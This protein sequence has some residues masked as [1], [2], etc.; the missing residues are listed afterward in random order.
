MSITLNDNIF[1]K[2]PKDQ[3][4]KT[5]VFQSGVWRPWNNIAE[6]LASDKLTYRNRG[7][8][9]YILKD[10]QLT[11]Y[12][13][14]D[15]ILD[16]QL[17]EKKLST[18]DYY[19]PGSIVPKFSFYAYQVNNTTYLFQSLVDNNNQPPSN[20][21]INWKAIGLFHM[22]IKENL[23]ISNGLN[24][25]FVADPNSPDQDSGDIVWTYIDEEGNFVEKSRIL[26]APAGDKRVIIQFDADED[27][28]YEIIHAN[29]IDEYIDVDL[30]DYY[31]KEDSDS[32]LNN[33]AN[34]SGQ[35]FT[36][37]ISAP[38]L[39]GV[40]T[41]DQDLSGLASLSGATFTGNIA[42]PNLSGLNT[43]DQDLTPILENLTTKQPYGTTLYSKSSW[44][45]LTDFT[46]T[47]FTPTISSNK[48]L[49]FNGGSEDATK[50]II[51][52]GLVNNDDNIDIEVMFRVLDITG[53]GIAIGK[54]SLFGANNGTVGY[55]ILANSL[56][57]SRELNSIANTISDF[58]TDP[59]DY[60][61]IKLSQRG[62]QLTAKFTNLSQAKSVISYRPG[63][64]INTS[65]IV[66]YNYGGSIEISQIKVTTASNRT[67][68]TIVMGDSK[69][70]IPVLQ[71]VPSF[72]QK[73]GIV[74]PYVGGSDRTSE[75]L[76]AVP[77]IIMYNAPCVVTVNY[78]RN[79][80]ATGIPSEVWQGNYTSAVTLLETAGFTVIHLLPIPETVTA[81]QSAL[82]NWIVAN[83]TK[84]VDVSPEWD[85]A[86][87][88]AGDGVHP[89]V[90]G[91]RLIA[92]KLINSGYLP[93]KDSTQS[94]AILSVEGEY[95]KTNSANTFLSTQTIA[96]AVYPN[97][98]EAK[99]G[100]IKTSLVPIAN[101][102]RL[103]GYRFGASFNSGSGM[104]TANIN[105]GG[106]GY[107]DGVYTGVPLL[108][109]AGAAGFGAIGTVTVSGGVVISVVPT[110][111]GRSYTGSHTFTVNPSFDGSG[112]GSGFIGQVATR[113]YTGVIKNSAVFESA[114][115]NLESITPTTWTNGDVWSQSNNLWTRQSGVS[116][117]L[118]RP[119][120]LGTV[121][122][123]I[124]NATTI[125]AANGGT[126]QTVYAIGDL[127]Y[128]STTSALSKRAA[129][130]TGNVLLS[131]GIGIAPIW[132]KVTSA[133]VDSSILTSSALTPYELLANKQNSL[134]VDGTGVKYLT[135]DAANAGL[136]SKVDASTSYI[137]NTTVMQAS[138]NF[139]IS[140][141]GR[142]QDLNI[143]NRI[144]FTDNP[145]I[146]G[147][148]IGNDGGNAGPAKTLQ[149]RIGSGNGVINGL[150]FNPNVGPVV[151][152]FGSNW[153]ASFGD[154]G[155]G[156]D[157]LNSV[158]G[159]GSRYFVMDT[160]VNILTSNLVGGGISNTSGI[161][162]FQPLNLYGGSGS[163]TNNNGRPINLRG[164][165]ATGSGT[166]GDIVLFY[167]PTATSGTTV[168]SVNT[169][170]VRLN[171]ATGKLTVALAPTNPTDVVR[172][173]E[174]DLKA[175]LPNTPVTV[176]TTTQQA[177]VNTKYITNN[178]ALV[179]ITLPLD[180]N[181]NIGDQVAIRGLG[182]GLWRLAQNALQVIHGA[183]D[184]TVG[185][186][187]Y[188]QAQSRYDTVVVEKITTNEWSIVANRGTLTIA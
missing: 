87:H 12:W 131:Q 178:A 44:N 136:L 173:V 169:E 48:G 58:T 6:A 25:Y 120:V 99:A 77:Y 32:L 89:N 36:G 141:V 116:Y 165:A 15:G 103:V 156:G 132:G 75:F 4:D 114:A 172:K 175:N 53:Y 181:A 64:Y 106:T 37:N 35:V 9:I 112:L 109:L 86:I 82:Y 67:P 129:V 29:N 157:I 31:T 125:A 91:A 127:L 166:T 138:S 143:R 135:V 163:G 51:L 168:N 111:G 50:Y 13:W 177:T 161:A 104:L 128:A 10:G 81:N 16:N 62:N 154:T 155:M 119:T 85:N 151:I 17:V 69:M 92:D 158:G 54:K 1:N 115:I 97:A 19:V 184:T 7:L 24:L 121:T 140:G 162:S 26:T 167:S 30:S 142:A 72:M 90:S 79:D 21:M 102:D 152:G 42:A 188:L 83:Y 186:A 23:F 66:V 56:Q 100:Y 105:S 28:Q 33:K 110:T 174:L 70:T 18:I 22:D 160:S 123:G 93:L 146:G 52:N 183:S 179:T 147:G 63:L 159:A 144:L 55:N 122:T 59:G 149:L 80:L 84:V 57:T 134:T 108:T 124:W 68:D 187:G 182:A 2:S 133:Q 27:Q 20:D 137:Q 126:G 176:T 61:I 118:S 49:V 94:D 47:G 38:N 98:G 74:S 39:S 171:G 14:R 41:G 139:N 145:N 76:A 40:N 170:A 3:N 180:V 150:L 45:D 101:N 43:G 107:L 60:C 34:V 164:G 130:A 65:N 78:G 5:G 71:R 11:E 46:A 73:V 96:G 148:Q 88:L 8:T 117:Q 95:A 113:G 153:N 185:T